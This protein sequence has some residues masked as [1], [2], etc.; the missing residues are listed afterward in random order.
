MKRLWPLGNLIAL[1]TLL[2]VL[3]VTAALSTTAA[4]AVGQSL[5]AQI[6][7]QLSQRARQGADRLDQFLGSRR[8]E[9]L[10]MASQR[11]VFAEEDPAAIRIAL[12]RLQAAI[13]MFSWVGFAG[14]DGTVLSATGGILEG[15][16]IAERPVFKEGLGGAFMGDVH[17][18]VLLATLL[19]NPTGETMRFIDISFRIDGETGELRGVLAAHLSWEWF[20]ELRNSFIS[21]VGAEGTDLLIVSAADGSV[22]LGPRA[23]VGTKGSELLP[24]RYQPTDGYFQARDASGAE[25]LY[26]AAVSRGDKDF[27]GFGWLVL[28]REPVSGAYAGLAAQRISLVMVGLLTAVLSAAAGWIMS[29]RLARSLVELN[30]KAEALRLGGREPLSVETSVREIAGLAESLDHLSASL[31]KMEGIALRDPLTG[32]HNRAG[33]KEWLAVSVPLCVR[34]GWNAAV[35]ALDL[36]GFKAVNDAHGH[37]AGDEVLRAVAVRFREV[38][39][40]DALVARWG[41]DEFVIVLI[42]TDGGGGTLASAVADRLLE[43]MR[44]GVP[45]QG[46]V[47]DVGCSIGGSVW[48]LSSND[49]WE[50]VLARADDALYRS[51]RAGKRRYTVS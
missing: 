28:V 30:R 40:A 20:Q 45:W 18:A 50:A 26:G 19:P 2:L 47:L 33:T 32:L 3:T 16:S 1:T 48:K 6:G 49:S 12:D 21:S 41:G 13:P 31:E 14:P 11:E 34:R 36:D 24:E 44:Q 43:S 8:M 7:L 9:L 29:R 46:R 42:D 27:P 39:R 15:K 10:L 51:K 35:L 23:A 37:E 38:V 4:A 22:I 17:D 5:K 25:Y